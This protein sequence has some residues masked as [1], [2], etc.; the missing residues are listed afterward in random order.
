MN[1]RGKWKKYVLLI[2]TNVTKKMV[3]EIL[4]LQSRT[5]LVKPI[6]PSTFVIQLR[7][8]IQRLG[9]QI[10]MIVKRHKR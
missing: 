1:K 9:K 8:S 2:K 5:L 7:G 6:L 4:M 10:E 3:Q